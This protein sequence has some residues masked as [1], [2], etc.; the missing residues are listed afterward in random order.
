VAGPGQGTHYSLHTGWPVFDLAVDY[1]FW[2][3]P[4]GVV[5]GDVIGEAEPLTGATPVERERS[6]ARVYAFAERERM[7]GAEKSSLARAPR[8]SITRTP[9]PSSR[10]ISVNT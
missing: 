8:T 5:P 4:A 10:A 7:G 6:T 3:R 9:T 2:K 1:M